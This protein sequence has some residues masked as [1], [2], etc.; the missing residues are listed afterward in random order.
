VI[1]LL[2][3]ATNA[4]AQT[5]GIVA[6]T[7]TDE[8]GQPLAGALVSV[9]GTDLEARTDEGGRYTIVG[10]SPG[11]HTVRATQVG[12]NAR[13]LAV[14]VVAGQTAAADFRLHA[15]AVQL[16]GI[17]AVGYG[18]QEKQ[19]VTGSI[20]TVDTT[21][22]E[23]APVS[24]VASALVG[25]VA[26]VTNRR[27]DAR[28]GSSTSLQ[29]RNLGTPLYV[30][31]GIPKDEGQFNNL[32][33]NDIES[34]S[35]LKDASAAAI[36]GVRAANGVVLVTTKKGHR[37][38]A[39]RVSV[40]TYYGMQSWD[41]F[42][43]ASDA[44]TFVRALIEADI[45]EQGETNW[46][47]E[48]LAKWE[49]GTEP[50]YRGFD[51]YDFAVHPNAP[52]SYIGVSSSGGTESINYYVSA[53]HLNED[54]VF[55]SW[56]FNRSNLQANVDANVSSR[57]KVGA[58]I[59]A[60][61]ETRQNPGVPGFDDYWQPLFGLYRNKPTERPYANDNPAYPATTSNIASNFALLNYDISGWW[62]NE[63]RVQQTNLNAEYE[64]PLAGLTAR[65]NYS[66]YVADDVEN[67]FEYTYDTYTYDPETD[68]YDVTGGN[69]NPFRDRWSRK[70]TENMLQLQV[71]YE[72]LFGR[73]QVKVDAAFER[74]DRQEPSYWIRSQP[75]SNYI[76]LISFNELKEMRDIM[77]ESA[78]M[79]YVLRADYN[80]DDRYLLEVAGRY[81]GS[82]MFA[83]E[84]RWGLFPSASAGWRVSNESFFQNSGLYDVV[85]ELKLRASY[86]ELGDDSPRLLGIGPFDYLQGYDF[87]R[88]SAVLDG[89]LITGIQPRGL[90]VRNLSWVRSTMANVGVD[91]GLFDNSLAGT[92]EYFNRTRRGL[93]A[94]RWDVLIPREVAIDLP[95]EN[96]NSDQ[97][98]GVEGSLS[99]TQTLGSGLRYS[100][101]GN[102]T[103]ARARDLSTY[104][105]RFGNSWD[106]YR[107][108]IEDRWAY[109]SWGY[110]V[111]GQFQSQEQIDDYP[112]DVDGRNN[113]SLLPGDFIYED[114]NGDGII[115]EL[116]ERPIGYRRGALPYATF[117][118]NG[119]AAYRSFDL[120]INFAGA[121]FQSFEREWEMKIPFQNDANSPAY[122]F[123]DH[124][125]H[126]DIFDPT[127]PWVPGTY[128]AL[129]KGM[130]NHSNMRRSDFWVTNVSYLRLKQLELGYTLPR[131]LLDRW[132]VRDARIYVNGGNLFSLDNVARYGIDPEIASGNGLQY[133]QQR[134][135][136]LGANVTL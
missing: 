83:P 40:S 16:E 65:A 55:K 134:T 33:V 133:P 41:R 112:V 21:V 86:G 67:T 3:W 48:E 20:S 14:P 19:T 106:E 73:S 29:I 7:V 12:Y 76:D 75:S 102:A 49:A 22:L 63:W 109:I 71:N 131:S 51:W 135:I 54:A 77:E 113:T 96:L 42:P 32:D 13:E 97:V 60:R 82:W 11:P 28:P 8:A 15:Q 117:G 72:K 80:Y 98:V 58:Q 105:P 37:G 122:I 111:I 110:Q 61:V 119:S 124:W 79:G 9:A 25:K 39:N 56:N 46:T 114:V 108:S 128:P 115:N 107:H 23:H 30:I 127:S 53:S 132:S 78:R 90:P 95:P 64:L 94:G 34:I 88:G 92:V 47:R 5:G 50:G 62:K 74:S 89:S 69:Q 26:G 123:G 4:V 2:L 129:R 1:P 66:Y 101:G 27:A 6:G 36:Y 87:R 68:S 45:N 10:V 91:F 118:L 126:E 100:L 93:P 81:D 43:E 125:H 99:F 38:Q 44:G 120:S 52:Q 24:T 57:L 59:N 84:E 85:S 31:D 104:K 116:D 121:G 136:T 130:V 70:V 17:V 103:F 18:T 35:I